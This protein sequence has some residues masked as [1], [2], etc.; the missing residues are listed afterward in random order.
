[1]E[2]SC[3][4]LSSSFLTGMWKC[5]NIQSLLTTDLIQPHSV[6]QLS[7]AGGMDGGD[8]AQ[9]CC[10]FDL[11]GIF[12]PASI[13]VTTCLAKTNTHTSF[14]LFYT[15][16]Y[17]PSSLSKWGSLS[18]I[19]I[20]TAQHFS[21]CFKTA[22]GHAKRNTPGCI[23]EQGYLSK[24]KGGNVLE[25]HQPTVCVWSHYELSFLKVN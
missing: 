25:E 2:G 1:V 14:C 15:H 8:G 9:G 20:Q 7:P 6:N 5:N 18:P 11:F 24:T 19:L 3:Q 13:L 4:N 22:N 23:S 12:P 17:S 16:T 21:L 10:I